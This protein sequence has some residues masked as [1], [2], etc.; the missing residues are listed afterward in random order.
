MK[1]LTADHKQKIK[2]ALTGKKKSKEAIEKMSQSLKEQIKKR[3]NYTCKMCGYKEIPDN[4]KLAIHH[5]DYNKNNLKEDNLISL[6][7]ECHGKTNIDRE[8]WQRTFSINK[9]VLIFGGT[10]S[11]GT[12]LVKQLLLDAHVIEITIFSRGEFAQ[13][14]M[15]RKFS[16]TKV[17]FIIGDVRDSNAVNEVCKN[18]DVVY[19]LS[20]LKHV[21]IC[22]NQPEEAIKTNITGVINVIEASI[23][24]GVHQVIDVSTDKACIPNTLYGATKA[25]GEKLVL[26]ANK[27]G[28]T[29]FKCIRA[30]NVLGSAGSVVPLFIDQ[31]KQDNTLT[32]TDGNMTRFF[33]SLPEAI[34][35]LLQAEMMPPNIDLLVMK[36]PSCT[37]KDLALVIAEKYAPNRKVE[38][39]EIGSR[40]SE[41]I[42]E[43]LI[44]EYESP[45]TYEFTD[46]Y[47]MISNKDRS[48]YTK[49]NFKSYGSNTQPLMNHQEI[50]T[51]L[52]RGG[53]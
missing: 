13:V 14:M 31:L 12:E 36:M 18:K 49:V 42:H 37:I 6:C 28:I 34:T 43:M 33:M 39:L 3:D 4:K 25:I 41:K 48:S 52:S 17:K 9:R 51:M 27:R 5:I 45:T 46:N 22:E 53:F 21:P 32:V 10:G 44:S 30:G 47:Y 1:V 8:Y 24:N 2:L 26:N 7:T 40:P 15:A 11:W 23:N 20:A 29:Y 50:L 19:L 16:N 35:L 38:I